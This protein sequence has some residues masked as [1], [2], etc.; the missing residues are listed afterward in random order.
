MIHQPCLVFFSQQT[1]CINLHYIYQQFDD[2]VNFQSNLNMNT[3]RGLNLCLNQMLCTLTYLKKLKSICVTFPVQSCWQMS[4]KPRALQQGVW[5]RPLVRHWNVSA[6][7][8]AQIMRSGI[9]AAT[10]RPVIHMRYILFQYSEY[11]KSAQAFRQQTQKATWRNIKEL[12]TL[13]QSSNSA[14]FSNIDT[15]LKISCQNEFLI[16]KC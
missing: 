14:T 12:L 16:C 3:Y 6:A 9:S 4:G 7:Q 5:S 15:F 10:V 13:I 8:G 1:Y 2:Q 11:R